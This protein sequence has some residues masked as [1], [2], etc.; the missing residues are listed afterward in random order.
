[1]S[2]HSSLR[3][4]SVLGSPKKPI[5]SVPQE[6][7]PHQLK[8]I[9]LF[10]E[11]E[12]LSN[13]NYELQR[14]NDELRT[15]AS[16]VEQSRLLEERLG[17]LMSENKNL[18]EIVNSFKKDREQIAAREAH[19]T[20]LEDQKRALLNDNEKNALLIHELNQELALWRNRAQDAEVKDNDLALKARLLSSENEDLKKAVDQK[21]QELVVLNTK[22]RDFDS[23]ARL[24]DDAMRK[25]AGLTAENDRLNTLLLSKTQ[26]HDDLRNQSNSMDNN[27]SLLVAE[28]E[29]LNGLLSLQKRDL[30]NMSALLVEKNK[31]LDQLK[32]RLSAAESEGFKAAELEK[33][34]QTLLNENMRLNGELNSK[35]QEL[36]DLNLKYVELEQKIPLIINENTRLNELLDAFQKQSSA[37]REHALEGER[38]KLE[39]AV[40]AHQLEALKNENAELKQTHEHLNKLIAHERDM[41]SD[42]EKELTRIPELENLVR[43]AEAQAERLAMQINERLK[44]T[45]YWKQKAADTKKELDEYV[46]QASK[47]DTVVRDNERLGGLLD[48][49]FKEIQAMEEKI[50]DLVKEAAYVEPLKERIAVLSAENE[51]LNHTNDDKARQLQEQRLRLLEA[52]DKAR[53]ADERGAQIERLQEEKEQLN[54]QLA[55]KLQETIELDGKEQASHRKINDLNETVIILNN[56]NEHLNQI[57]KEKMKEFEDQREK[58]IRLQRELEGKLGLEAQVD[59]LQRDFLHLSTVLDSKSKEND[60]LIAKNKE[61]EEA[62]SDKEDRNLLLKND[63]AHLESLLANK[64]RESELQVDKVR[65]LESRLGRIPELEQRLV[66]FH[67]ENERLVT[68]LNEK[69]KDIELLKNKLHGLEGNELVINDLQN[70]LLGMSNENQRLGGLVKERAQEI[71]E[72]R[73]RLH[74]LDR[75]QLRVSDLQNKLTLLGTENERLNANLSDAVKENANLLAQLNEQQ[76]AQ[77]NI[78]KAR[79]QMARDFERAI[80]ALALENKNAQEMLEE[81]NRIIEEQSDMVREHDHIVSHNRELLEQVEELQHSNQLLN[82]SIHEKLLEITQQRVRGDAAEAQKIEND[83]LR[84]KLAATAEEHRILNNTLN[85]KTRRI[86]DLESK[87]DES[88]VKIN[89]LSNEIERLTKTWNV[90]QIDEQNWRAKVLELQRE[91]L[92]STDLEGKLLLVANESQKLDDILKERTREFE[93]IRSRA[94]ELETKVAVLDMEN[95]TLNSLVEEKRKESERW[96]SRVANTELERTSAAEIDMKLEIVLQENERLNLLLNEKVKELESWRAKYLTEKSAWVIE[97]AKNSVYFDP[98]RRSL[99]TENQRLSNFL[100]SRGHSP[101]YSPRYNFK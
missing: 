4:S 42:V 56:E 7:D 30:D 29:R 9:L 70:K 8:S 101:T 34:I 2:H 41:R 63:N 92:E 38:S 88:R 14:E 13:I 96:M 64:M 95:K 31:E 79:D 18:H 73:E 1:M 85:E 80:E 12:R 16:G 62:N 53:L 55:F 100:S 25:I 59:Q 28:T 23:Q 67:L 47:V 44:D 77:H 24:L 83:A 72:L 46:H 50:R 51:R 37:L 32:T 10:I 87:L 26:A 61:L 99:E 43:A 22:L 39:G 69:A 93:K 65:E 78:E 6:I 54:K 84:H 98:S 97:S 19:I 74:Q 21:I 57:I 91:K 5:V 82:Q 81:K 11:I 75:V 20:Q 33:S 94:A 76:R 48:A 66:G 58:I 45:E 71:E 15:Q 3:S 60:A 86:V 35:I 68:E 49:K 17:L 40:L 89:S 90:M 27:L 36:R 52:E